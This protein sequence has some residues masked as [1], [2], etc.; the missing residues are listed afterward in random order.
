MKTKYFILAATAITMMVSCADEKFVGDENLLGAGNGEEAISFGSGFKAI[1][2]ADKTG[3]EAATLLNNQFVVG[4]YKGNGTAM[5]EVF[6]NYIVNYTANTAATTESNTA[7]WEYV[8]VTAAAPSA[9]SGTQTIKYWDQAAAQ[10]DFAAYSVGTKTRITDGTPTDAQVKVTAIAPHSPYAEYGLTYSLTGTKAGLS[11]CYISNMTTE[12][13]TSKYNT[14]VD[15]TFR[16]LA[17]KIRVGIYETVPGYSVKD[18]YF[19]QDP[20]TTPITADI[21]SNTSATLLGTDAFKAGGTYTIY[22]PTIGSTN[23]SEADYNRAH[24]TYSADTYAED[25]LLQ[26]GALTYDA[27]ERSETGGSIYLKRTSATPSWANSG[28]YTTVLPNETGAGLEL[29]VN[30]TLVPIDGADETIVVHGAKAF[31]PSVYAKW[32]SN[33]AY[34]YLFKISDNTNGWTNT[35]SSDPAGLYPI[36]FDAIVAETQ[37]GTETITT[38]S[39]PSITSYQKGSNAT[40]NNEYATG[41]DI[42]VVVDNEGTVETLV[43]GTIGVTDASSNAWLYE[44]T[45]ETGALQDI[46]EMTVDNAIANGVYDGTAGTYTVTD[47]NDKDLVVKASAVSLS[48]ITEIADTDSPTGDAITVNGTKFSPAAGKTYVFQYQVTKPTFD[49]GETLEASTSLKGY[50]TKSSDTYTRCNDDA[51]AD[52]TTTYYKVAT[53]G[54]YQYK[55]IKVKP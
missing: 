24:V 16:S 41:K 47:A 9:V 4:G 45:V 40:V 35:V 38:V 13:Q 11:A 6:D 39:T 52:G 33:Y 5:T 32:L 25:D 51:V 50:Y 17:A 36:T 20:S 1:T 54:V 10:Y 37:D 31:I 3:A 48:A 28:D 18:V 43:V 8:G 34:T 30:Y 7:N 49:S 14:E 46:T 53:A 22:F 27:A 15:L 2:R 55:V 21:S 23:T 12:Y 44:A 19:Y 26:L 42:Y 29:R